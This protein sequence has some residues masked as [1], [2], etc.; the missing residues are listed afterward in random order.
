MA[1]VAFY[2]EHGAELGTPKVSRQLPA[3]TLLITAPRAGVPTTQCPGCPAQ[4][5]PGAVP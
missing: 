3:S 2:A 1:L 4:E 5:Q